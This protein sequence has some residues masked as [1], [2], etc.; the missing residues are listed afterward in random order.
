MLYN[1][2]RHTLAPAR[3]ESWGMVDVQAD[4]TGLAIKHPH[5]SS[6]D[7]ARQCTPKVSGALTSLDPRWGWSIR[8]LAMSSLSNS[9]KPRTSCGRVG[10]GLAGH[11]C[12]APSSVLEHVMR[13]GGRWDA[14]TELRSERQLESEISRTEAAIATPLAISLNST[15]LDSGRIVTPVA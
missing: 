2:Y 14:L 6:P 12:L 7:W 5:R 9:S 15:M 10:L 4:F 11:G 3:S 1:N 13:A 8:A